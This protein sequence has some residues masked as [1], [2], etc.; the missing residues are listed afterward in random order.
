MN[1]IYFNADDFGISKNISD[2]I[3]DLS[4]KNYINSTSIFSN[5]IYFKEIKKKINLMPIEKG[6]HFSLTE[7]LSLSKSK[8]LADEKGFLK[9]SGKDLF[10]YYIS[11]SLNKKFYNQIFD[12]FESQF[13]NL[14]NYCKIQHISSHEHVH[15]IPPIFNYLLDFSLKKKIKLRF[16]NEDLFT[17]YSLD[18]LKNFFLHDL[19][20]LKYFLIYI[21]SNFNKSKHNKYNKTYGV[22]FS[23][24]ISYQNILQ[25]SKKITNNHILFI[26]LHP[27]YVLQNKNNYTNLKKYDFDFINSPC[28]QKE[29][30]TVL[31]F[32]NLK[33]GIK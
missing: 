26:Y 29:L 10:R 27:G 6:L 12:E 15:M 14:S 16:F 28:R 33:N 9:F 8:L 11:G 25:Y 23:G 13:E 18:D 1:N 3:L 7:G 31:E 32:V 4:F 17:F 24:S 22:K 2:C 20:F 30:K 5:T 21:L 19:N